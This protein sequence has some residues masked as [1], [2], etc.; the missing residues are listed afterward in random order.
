MVHGSVAKVMVVFFVFLFLKFQ[1]SSSGLEF[2]NKGKPAW[3]AWLILL[4]AS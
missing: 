2:I 1:M 3:T 4:L